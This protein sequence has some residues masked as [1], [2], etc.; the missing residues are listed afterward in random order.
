MDLGSC[1]RTHS[2]KVKA[3]YTISMAKATEEKDDQKVAEL[4][5]LKLEYENTVSCLYF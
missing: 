4:N 1:N 3:E 2:N 5:R